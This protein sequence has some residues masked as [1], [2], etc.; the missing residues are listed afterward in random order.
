MLKFSVSFPVE[1][2]VQR[3]I[4]KIRQLLLRQRLALRVW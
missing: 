3:H 2:F 1:E 4:I